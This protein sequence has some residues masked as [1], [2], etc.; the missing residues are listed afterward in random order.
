MM[1]SMGDGDDDEWLATG[2]DISGNQSSSVNL[3]DRSK[4][5]RSMDESGKVD[6]EEGEGDDEDD[7]IPDMED[8]DDDDEAIIRDRRPES[9]KDE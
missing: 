6:E 4:E 2:G 7:E 5:V 1:I 3:R 8:E 9:G